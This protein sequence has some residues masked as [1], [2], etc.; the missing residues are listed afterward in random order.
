M[1]IAI[2]PPGPATRSTAD[3]GWWRWLSENPT[4]LFGSATLIQAIFLTAAIWYHA[5]FSGLWLPGVV[6]LLGSLVLG[7]LLQNLPVKL[8][9]SPVDYIR[10]ASLFFLQLPA[11][12]LLLL[13]AMT[14]HY[15]LAVVG[16]L[17]A[18]VVWLLLWRHF[19]WQLQ[20]A[21]RPARPV[22]WVVRYGLPATLICLGSL[23]AV[24]LLH[25]IIR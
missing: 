13:Y 17:L 14:G 6:G 9:A 12:V 23:L 7:W 25:P 22:A 24:S 16:L 18:L 20:W 19:R 11:G 1:C 15:W 2:P 8:G 21:V 5:G 4:R 10:Y 3:P